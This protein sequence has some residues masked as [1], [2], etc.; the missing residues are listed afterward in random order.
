MLAT[1]VQYLDYKERQRHNIVS[2]EQNAADVATRAKTLEEAIRHNKAYEQETQRHNVESENINWFNAQ[3]NQRHNIEGEAI[4]WFNAREQQRH[5][6]VWEDQGQQTINE[7]VRH[8]KANEGI[9]WANVSL[10]YANL[11][12]TRRHNTKTEAQQNR[13]LSINAADVQNRRAQT[14]VAYMN[15]TT[16]RNDVSSRIKVNQAQIDKYNSD[17]S[18]NRERLQTEE[19]NQFYAYSGAFNNYTGGVK[20]VFQSFN[21]NNLAKAISPDD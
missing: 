13:Q 21:A 12:E 17:I 4:G 6:L 19:A 1:Q 5:N 9:G 20:N 2:E 15:A 14:T 11:A 16:N 10:G 8:N 18:L 7:T 3:E